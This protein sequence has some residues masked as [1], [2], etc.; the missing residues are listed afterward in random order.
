[1]NPMGPFPKSVRISSNV[2]EAVNKILAQPR[3]ASPA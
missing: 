3:G 2:A 1:V